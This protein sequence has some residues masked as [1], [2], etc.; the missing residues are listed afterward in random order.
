MNDTRKT[1]SRFTRAVFAMYAPILT[2]TSIILTISEVNLTYG[3]IGLYVAIILVL[4][5]DKSNSDINLFTTFLLVLALLMVMLLMF[6]TLPFIVG[7]VNMALI[8]ML[9]TVDGKVW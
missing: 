5:Q 6:S 3:F 1:N 2:S 8:I 9:A 7:T 4:F